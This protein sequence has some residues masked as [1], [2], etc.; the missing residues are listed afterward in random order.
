MAAR[1]GAQEIVMIRLNGYLH[2]ERLGL[3]I[4]RWLINRPLPEDARAL[5]RIVNFNGYAGCL[6]LDAFAH[7]LVS[8]IH[9]CPVASCAA[10]TKGELKDFIVRQPPRD[11]TP[12]VD[13]LIARYRRD[14]DGYFRETPFNGRVYHA[15]ENGGRYLGS[16]R[17]KRFHR[18]AEKTSRYLIDHLFYEVKKRAEA[19]ADERAACLGVARAQLRTPVDEQLAEFVRAEGAVQEMFRSGSFVGTAPSMN[20]NDVLGVKVVVDGQAGIGRVT[21]YLERGAGASIVDRQTHSG[22]YNATTLVV[23]YRWP[24]DLVL[25]HTPTGPAMAVLRER[26]CSCHIDAE[27]RA[28]IE[29]AEDDVLIEVIVSSYEDMLESEIGR[30][31]HEERVLMQRENRQYHG[32]LA[33][34]VEYLVDFMFRFC[35]APVE[36]LTELPIRVWVRYMPDYVDQIQLR[37]AGLSSEAEFTQACACGRARS[38]HF[39]SSPSTP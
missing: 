7:A 28:F 5:K 17:V 24:R 38:G 6:I 25:N 26:G 12:R 8:S 27:F 33:R 13:E 21:E 9:E 36:D 3:L 15:S 32:S 11:S 18:I 14:P 35:L 39:M 31:M 30:S 1:D 22:N 2:R 19:L 34:N 23:R 37:L 29:D 4:D 16:A 10:K 20:V